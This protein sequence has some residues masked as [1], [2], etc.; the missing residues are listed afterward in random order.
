M[1]DGD[2]A[3]HGAFRRDSENLPHLLLG[4]HSSL[5]AVSSPDVAPAGAKPEILGLVLHRDSR[6]GTVL[7]PQF[8]LPRLAQNGDDNRSPG[9]KL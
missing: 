8:L 4:A 2:Q 9:D 7:N 1:P 5:L 6:Y 3:Q